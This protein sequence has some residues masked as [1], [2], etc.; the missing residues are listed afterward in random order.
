MM[1]IIQIAMLVY[2]IVSRR[3]VEM[4]SVKLLVLDKMSNAMT[5]TIAIMTLV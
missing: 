2:L 5:V 1:G 3:D 4:D